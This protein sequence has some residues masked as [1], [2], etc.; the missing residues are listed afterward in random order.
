[1][2]NIEFLLKARLIRIKVEDKEKQRAAIEMIKELN[3]DDNHD[4]E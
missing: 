4:T 2:K 1:M 3:P